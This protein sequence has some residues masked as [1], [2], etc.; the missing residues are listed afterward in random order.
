MFDESGICRKCGEDLPQC[1]A[2]GCNV[3]FREVCGIK[4]CV[5]P[6]NDV[7]WAHMLSRDERHR[8]TVGDLRWLNAFWW[9][10]ARPPIWGRKMC[11]DSADEQ[12]NDEQ[13]AE[14]LRCDREVLTELMDRY[15]NETD[16]AAEI[17]AADCELLR[18]TVLVD[19]EDV[20]FDYM[21]EACHS[22]ASSTGRSPSEK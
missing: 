11:A 3:C 9:G 14:Q 22:T 10:D 20:P 6:Q 19:M 4:C 5:T 2:M 1:G 13:V 17:T 21:C 7:T 8:L 12:Y 15:A 18:D 16:L